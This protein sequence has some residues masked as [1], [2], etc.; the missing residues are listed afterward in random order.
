MAKTKEEILKGIH[1]KR[2]VN[3]LKVFEQNPSIIE[4]AYEAMDEYA[5]Q[6]MIQLIENISRQPITCYSQKIQGQDKQFF[7]GRDYIEKLINSIN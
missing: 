2:I 4:S 7:L 5:K 3:F 6:Q 1:A